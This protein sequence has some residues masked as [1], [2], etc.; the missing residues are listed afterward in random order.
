MSVLLIRYWGTS[1]AYDPARPGVRC[2]LNGAGIFSIAMN[3]P[4]SHHEAEC[5]E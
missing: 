1:E 3:L 2:D 5:F 4:F